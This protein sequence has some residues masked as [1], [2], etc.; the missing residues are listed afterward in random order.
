LR[1]YVEQEI[2]GISLTRFPN[3]P[4]KT[5]DLS[6]GDPTNSKEFRT[7]PSNI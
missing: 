4:A 2:K 5:V 6:I 3:R 7:H 1:N